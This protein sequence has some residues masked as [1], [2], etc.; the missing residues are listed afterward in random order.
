M[1]SIP[2]KI[3]RDT[4]GNKDFITEQALRVTQHA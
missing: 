1:E 3:R 4:N 2:P